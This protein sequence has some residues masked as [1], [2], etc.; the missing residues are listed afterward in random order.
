MT[1]H[2]VDNSPLG[3]KVFV[4]GKEIPNTYYA[5]TKKGVVRA[6]REPLKADKYG[7]RVIEKT[8]RGKVEVIE[9]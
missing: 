7:K 2:T 5:D 3:T 9:P 1:I 6:Y 8:Y 4:N